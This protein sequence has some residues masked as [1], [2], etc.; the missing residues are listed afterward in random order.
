M[1]VEEENSKLQPHL[2]IKNVKK[3]PFR[4]SHEAMRNQLKSFETILFAVHSNL[5]KYEKCPL[6][7]VG[8][9]FDEE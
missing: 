5:N 4:I 6:Q 3:S 2:S 8:K 1:N 9:T 7:I